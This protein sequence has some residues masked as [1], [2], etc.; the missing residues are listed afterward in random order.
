[1]NERQEA[2]FEAGAGVSAQ[3]ASASLAAITMTLALVWAV[4]ISVGTFRAW[5][6]GQLLLADLTWSVLRVA[7]VLMVF[8]VV[9]N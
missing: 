8:G 6:D 4:W 9:L 7:I 3:V 2:A 5:F 1:M